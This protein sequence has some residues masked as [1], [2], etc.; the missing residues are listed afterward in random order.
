MFSAIIF[1][2]VCQVN[3]PGPQ[4]P[5]PDLPS[6]RILLLEGKVTDPD[7]KPVPNCP[8]YLRRSVIREFQNYTVSPYQTNAEGKY[9]IFERFDEPFTGMLFASRDFTKE[10]GGSSSFGSNYADSREL[11][12]IK[13]KR[14][15]PLKFRVTDD[16]GKPIAN[17]KIGQFMSWLELE[18]VIPKK[19]HASLLKTTDHD[20]QAEVATVDSDSSSLVVELPD[21]SKR[22]F[23]IQTINRQPKG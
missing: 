16:A 7:G 23:A 20:G 18:K 5:T 10:Y 13:L 15:V 14:V 1:A 17:A 9:R 21:G 3:A 22:V 12:T 4:Q 19:Y 11:S 8:L 6:S 2:F